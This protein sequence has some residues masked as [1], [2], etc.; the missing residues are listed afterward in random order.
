MSKALEIFRTNEKKL[1][2]DIYNSILGKSTNSNC[3]DD[4]RYNCLI[5]EHLFIEDLKAPNLSAVNESQAIAINFAIKNPLTLIQG[6]PGTGKTLTSAVLVYNLL[7]LKLKGKILVSAPS[8]VA[9]DHLANKIKNIGLKVIRL[10]GKTKENDRTYYSPLSIHHKLNN[11]EPGIIH[12]K[13][14]L[15]NFLKLIMTFQSGTELANF[16]ELPKTTPNYFKR[17][18]RLRN[19]YSRQL[20]LEAEVICVTCCSSVDKRL[21]GIKFSTLLIDE[22]CQATGKLLSIWNI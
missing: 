20:I 14:Q 8:N 18:R 22:V 3:N 1:H 15:L 21:D 16:M 10:L 13:T 17:L 9:C 2:S 6:P 5:D 11:P 4:N 12:L 19:E 7:K